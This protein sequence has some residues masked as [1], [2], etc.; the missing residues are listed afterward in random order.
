VIS[1]GER[2]D[3]IEM[4]SL[5][6][7]LKLSG[8]VAGV[9]SDFKHGDY[10][11]FYGDGSLLREGAATTGEKRGGKESAKE[12]LHGCDG[13]WKK[14]GVGNRNQGVERKIVRW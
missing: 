4:I 7:V 2:V 10:Y 3:V 9:G 5:D 12:V 8:L 14:Q 11:N 1:S 13:K 6:P